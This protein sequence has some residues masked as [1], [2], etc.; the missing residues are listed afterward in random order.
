MGVFRKQAFGTA[1]NY[2]SPGRTAGR[3]SSPYVTAVGGTQLQYGWR[4][5]TRRA[6]WPSTPT[7]ASTRAV[8]GHHAR[9]DPVERRLERVVVPVAQRAAA[10]ARLY[11]APE[12][13]DG[14]A[15]RLQGTTALVPDLAW[16]ASVNGG[17]LVYTS[18]FPSVNRVGWHIYGGTSASSA[19]GCRG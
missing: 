8:L 14:S 19:A 5:E 3:A 12:L 6:T 16:N 1:V 18:F 13:A 9:R 17:V 7:G 10:R 15:C 4:W 11:R 2:T